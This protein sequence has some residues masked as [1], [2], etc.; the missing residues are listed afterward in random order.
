MCV[1]E[2]SSLNC[3]WCDHIYGLNTGWHYCHE[4]QLLLLDVYSVEIARSFPA[5]HKA[6]AHEIE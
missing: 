3:K 6:V 4:H 1:H 2:N 5:W